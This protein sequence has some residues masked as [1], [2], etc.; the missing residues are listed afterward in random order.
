MRKKLFCTLT[1][2]LA[3]I[4]VIGCSNTENS[5][6]NKEQ[7]SNNVITMLG[8]YDEENMKKTIDTINEELNGEITLEYTFVNLK[9]YNNVLSTQLAAGEGP[10]IISD[11]A[12]FPARIK[13]G[14]LLDITK[15]E[16]LQDFNESGLQL[17]SANNKIY[18][19]PSYGWYSGM[20]Y[21]KDIFDEYNLT[22]PETFDELIKVSDVL[23]E[24]GIQPLG[25]GLSDGDT[26]W[27]SLVGYL[28]NEYYH[29]G[30]PG[31]KFDEEF[32]LGE[33][34]LNGNVNDYVENWKELINKGF[35][36]EKMLG[37][38]GEQ[39]LADFISGKTA[40]F[41]GG[42]WQ[43][44]TLKNAG[45]NFGMISHLG[46]NPNEKWLVGGPAVNFGINK[47]SKNIENAKKVLK[48]IASE[49][50]QQTFLESNTGAFS[51]F[52]G[53]EQELPEEYSAISE[54]L[55]SGRVGVNWDRWGVNMPAQTM[56]DEGI[57]QLQGMI[58]GTTDT[59]YF[60]E[61]LDGKADSIRYKD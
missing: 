7:D 54:I 25:F 56:I 17:T 2:L 52:K 55:S 43:Y 16:Y 20:W 48:V 4:V 8:W 46:S 29:N 3:M 12:S 24:K 6:K 49:K 1:F 26:V 9:Q 61:A 58:S 50:V 45:L 28:E 40:F 13:A 36:N 22:P 38:S 23:S 41:N 34:K 57:K 5:V 51:Y 30:G 60:L 44:E 14:Y 18:G 10:D 47:N 19:I 15:E 59:E 33:E 31:T 42:P 39:A 27:H 32:A 11:G 35:I 53:I 37:L 21:N